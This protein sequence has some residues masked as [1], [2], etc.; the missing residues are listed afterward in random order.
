MKILHIEDDKIHH[1][2]IKGL[3][4]Q[5]YKDDLDITWR[6]AVADGIDEIVNS[7]NVYD[8][9]LQ[10]Y[11]LGDGTAADVLENIDV[12]AI[13][14]PVIVI[15][16]FR[17]HEFDLNAL[18]RGADDYLLKGQFDVH[19]L[20]RAI[21]YSVYKK[22]KMQ[23]L[24]QYAFHDHLTGLPNRHFLNERTSKVVSLSLRLDYLVGVLYIDVNDFKEIN[25]THGH[26]IGDA[27]LIEIS[28]RIQK[29]IRHSDTAF[30]LGGDEFLIVAPG[31]KNINQIRRLCKKLVEALADDMTLE[32]IT[33]SPKCSI[34]VGVVPHHG[35]DLFEV[36]Q[37]A[38]KAMYEAKKSGV[39]MR[40]VM[41]QADKKA[42]KV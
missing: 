17:D 31:I 15:S 33:L 29:H 1:K 25:D 27:V 26:H 24:A 6:H 14:S 23:A 34:G 39:P 3:L 22:K 12:G 7:G 18:Q 36:M 32:G 40:L 13:P 20:E 38:D 2:F 35:K 21:T 16:A 5:I 4:Q 9:I 30:R 11:M 8:V 19:E 10:D 42:G 37:V 41:E 28:K